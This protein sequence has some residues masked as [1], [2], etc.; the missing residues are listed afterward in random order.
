MAMCDICGK[1]RSS[2]NN[3]SFS[4][5]KTKRVFRPNIQKARV[6]KNGTLQQVNACTR[7]IRT[8]AKPPRGL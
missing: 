6:L 4:N 1:T 5:K 3:V 7:C 8:M 2:G